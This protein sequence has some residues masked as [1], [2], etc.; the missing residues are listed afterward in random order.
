MSNGETEQGKVQN[1]GTGAPGPRV[2]FI[3]EPDEP[4]KGEGGRPLA[5]RGTFEQ[6]DAAKVRRERDLLKRLPPGASRIGGLPDLR[7]GVAWPTH[8]GKKMP[9]LVQI[10]LSEVFDRTGGL[11]PR[12]GW[13]YA[14]G[15]FDLWA[16]HNR[17]AVFI[18]RG[19]RDA[20]RRA[21]PPADDEIRPN[22]DQRVYK[23]VPVSPAPAK[24][25]DE[26]IDESDRR[27]GWLLGEMDDIF[28]TPGEIAGHASREGD[29]WINLLAI[30]SI[31]SMQWSDCGH[32]YLLVRRSD[33]AKGDLSQVLASVESS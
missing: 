30:E 12:D 32:L 6:V 33:L 2:T 24:G 9:F 7:P 26:V 20:L 16:A 18:D 28:G 19:P 31:G 29:D 23:L 15:R 8:E 14:F 22:F 17:V 1:A 5:G 27:A 4:L 10:D 3:A 21:S 13:L 25:V 11:L